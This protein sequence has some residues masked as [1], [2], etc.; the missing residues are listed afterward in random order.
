[1][2]H[3]DR[4]LQELLD[5]VAA[6]TPAPGGG[7]TA[8]WATAL[9][10]ALVEMAASFSDRPDTAARAGELRSTALELAE[11][12]LTAYEPVLEAMRLPRDDRTRAEQLDWALS[13]AA[14][15][16]REIARAAGE[17]AELANE[18]V[19]D[20]NRTLE[21][22]ANTAALLAEAAGKAAARLTE[23]NLAQRSRS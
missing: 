13:Q 23:I 11:H 18:L 10:A 8:A 21:G 1:M 7:S 6:R 3:A 9:A 4:T 15:S 20:G 17:V 5:E 14:D 16:P 19:R 22:D 2:G 12:E